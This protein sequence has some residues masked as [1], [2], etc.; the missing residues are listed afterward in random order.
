M[1]FFSAILLNTQQHLSSNNIQLYTFLLSF[2]PISL[3]LSPS[4]F[5][6]PL[7][8][9][10]PFPPVNTVPGIA[11]NL[12]EVLGNMMLIIEETVKKYTCLRK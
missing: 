7:S 4:L 6:F 8:L 11:K 3:Y 2:L 1:K 9:L 5:P 12:L 10:P